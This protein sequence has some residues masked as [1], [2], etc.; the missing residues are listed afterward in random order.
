MN[1][2]QFFALL[3]LPNYPRLDCRVS[4]LVF[5]QISLLI[6]FVIQIFILFQ[7]F[8]SLFLFFGCSDLC[9]YFFFCS[10]LCFY[11]LHCS[12]LRSNC[13]KRILL[14]WSY[15]WLLS[16]SKYCIWEMVVWNW[17]LVDILAQISSSTKHLAVL[18]IAFLSIVSWISA[19]PV[20]CY[21]IFSRSILYLVENGFL[22]ARHTNWPLCFFT[23]FRIAS[24]VSVFHEQTGHFWKQILCKL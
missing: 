19:S 23:C 4:S 7:S 11:F 21:S 5:V 13:D 3:L 22:Q 16:L 8:R 24:F 17:I 2:E 12:D 15:F 1:A 20:Y 10:D 9:S 14:I 6:F 18:K